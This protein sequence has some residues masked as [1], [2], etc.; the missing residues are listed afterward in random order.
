MWRKAQSRRG[1][2]V[3]A[4]QRFK[5]ARFAAPARTATCRPCPLCCIHRCPHCRRAAGAGAACTAARARW[6]W[7]RRSAPTPGPGYS[8]PPT[9]ASS[10]GWPG[11]CDFFGGGGLEILTLPDWEVL[12]YDVFSPH[13][14]IVSERLRTLARLPE[15]RR[16]I[17]LLSA[18]SLLTRLPP[19]GYVQARSFELQRGAPLA[20]EPLRLQLAQS[21]Y[22]SVSQVDQPRAN[23]RCAAR[24][25]TCFRWAASMPVRVD[26]LDDRIDSIRRFDPEYAALARERRAA[27]TAAGAR[28][29]ARCRGGP[30][31][32]SP[33]SR[34][35]RGRRHAHADLSRRQR[36][37]RAARH[38]V[39]PAAVLRQPRR[40]SPTTCRRGW[41]SPAMPTSMQR[42]QRAWEGIGARYED[43]RHDIER[44]LLPPARRRSSSRPRLAARSRRIP[45]SRIERFAG[46]ADAPRD[47]D[48]ARLSQHRAA[49]VPARCARRAAARAADQLSR[50]LCR[51]GADRR[52]LAG[53]A[54]SHRRDARRPTAAGRARCS[55]GSSSPPAMRGSASAS[56]RTSSGWRWPHPPLL[57]LGGIAAVRHA[58]APG[59]AAT[60]QRAVRSGRDPARSAE[61][62]ARRAGG[63]RDLRRRPLRRPAG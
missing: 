30:R 18:D 12:P 52:R 14:D 48:C 55:P 43:R 53:A 5:L 13:P 2:L 10:S 15:L 50:Q 56:P 3:F 39:L 17:L 45:A 40:R 32:P 29:A 20:I 25:S 24:C 59:A 54:R 37:H 28:A 36:R 58:R 49:G 57:L 60:A 44:P 1:V 22:A 23:S 41:W 46:S 7:P 31:I 38:R 47:G 4:P 61:P 35:L 51:P 19:V 6:R 62:G 26:L 21:G 63:A 9:R 33:L 11:S 8:S 27:A 16:G 34:A 42:S